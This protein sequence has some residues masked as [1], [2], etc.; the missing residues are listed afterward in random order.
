MDVN[1]PIDNKP[2]EET[3]LTLLENFVKYFDVAQAFSK[4]QKLATYKIRYH[5]YVQE[6]GYIPS[7]E[8]YSKMETDDYDGFSWH[9]L[10]THRRT[11]MPAACARLIPASSFTRN[12][13]LPIEV[14]C[15][16]VAKKDFGSHLK[17]ERDTTCEV[18]RVIVDSAFRSRANERMNPYGNIDRVDVNEKELRSFPML[19]IAV[20]LASM[21]LVK[22]SNRKHVYALMEPT[23]SRFLAQ[24]GIYCDK[25]GTL[26][27]YKGQRFPYYVEIDHAIKYLRPD[28]AELYR[29]IF[30]KMSEMHKAADS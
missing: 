17:H 3:P 21:A 29:Y 8:C 14:I 2:A 28:V 27:D 10:I 1:E 20:I 13:K 9:C 23:T 25:A 11:G 16:D 7:D 30:S 12:H 19:A 15:Q 5:V 24:Q 18:S 22:L 26:V 6:L 4:D